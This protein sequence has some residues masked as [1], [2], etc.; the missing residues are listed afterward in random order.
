MGVFLQIAEGGFRLHVIILD[1]TLN[2]RTRLLSR[3]FAYEREA[4]TGC[5]EVCCNFEAFYFVSPEEGL[6]H[7]IPRFSFH[8]VR[9]ERYR[10]KI[11]A[12]QLHF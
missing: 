9:L 4:G 6:T 5:D 11:L 12:N 8:N 2:A 1:S 7:R 3:S 10:N